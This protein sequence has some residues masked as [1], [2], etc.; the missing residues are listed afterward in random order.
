M[1]DDNG[2]TNGFLH[3]MAMYRFRITSDGQSYTIKTWAIEGDETNHIFDEKELSAT[4]RPFLAD[5]CKT[6]FQRVD[7]SYTADGTLMME[8]RISVEKLTQ[9]GDEFDD[10]VEKFLDVRTN[11]RETLLR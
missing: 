3:G 4:V 2:L 9:D 11:V 8:A 5:A 10:A 1:V 6:D 7:L